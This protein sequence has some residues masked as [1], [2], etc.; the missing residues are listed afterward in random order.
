V[1]LGVVGDPHPLL[2]GLGAFLGEGAGTDF[3]E[4]LTVEGV[5]LAEDGG[6]FDM[7]IEGEDFTPAGGLET[8]RGGLGVPVVPDGGELVEIPDTHHLDS[9]KGEG[10]VTDGLGEGVEGIEEFIGQHT[11]LI[12]DEGFDTAPFFGDTA[13]FQDPLDDVGFGAFPEPDTG[14]GMDGFDGNRAASHTD[15]IGEED[16]RA[17]GGGG[18]LVDFSLV[19]EV[20]DQVPDEVTFTGT[21][22]TTDEEVVPPDEPVVRVTLFLGEFFHGRGYDMGTT[23]G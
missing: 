18:D 15:T 19:V 3:V 5:T 16:G 7:V 8:E 1:V 20:V 9:P 23:G 13:V 22:G 4:N 6:E 11:D 2:E 10:V 21:S 14:P 17:P 12:D